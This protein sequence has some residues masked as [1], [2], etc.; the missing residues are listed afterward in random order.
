MHKHKRSTRTLFILPIVF[1]VVIAT[2]ITLPRSREGEA[3][4][5]QTQMASARQIEGKVYELAQET[6]GEAAAMRRSKNR[7]YQRTDVVTPLTGLP[8]GLSGVGVHGELPPSTP[9]PVNQSAVVIVGKIEEAQPYLSENQTSIYTEFT[10]QIQEVLKSDFS[11]SSGQTIVADREGGALR[12]STGRVV[13]FVVGSQGPMPDKGGRYVFFL[14]RTHQGND[15]NILAAYELVNG[16]VAP[17]LV[18]HLYRGE[19]VSVF[20][21]RIRYAIAHPEEEQTRKAGVQ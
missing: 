14:E 11:L 3:S 18:G 17:L 20:L 5:A 1:G 10:I 12:L 15:L 7:R 4:S 2:L 8:S 21:E 6:T 16:K 13:R 19:M 9:F